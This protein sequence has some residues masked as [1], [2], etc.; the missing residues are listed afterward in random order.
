MNKYLS[1]A[2]VALLILVMW[3]A[4]KIRDQEHKYKQSLSI[5]IGLVQDFFYNLSKEESFPFESNIPLFINEKKILQ[6]IL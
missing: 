4:D 5:F 6:L 1:I 2:I 3:G